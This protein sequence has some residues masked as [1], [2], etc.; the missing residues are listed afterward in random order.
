MS[1]LYGRSRQGGA[2]PLP[3]SLGTNLN[4]GVMGCVAGGGKTFG[5]HPCLPKVWPVVRESWG[6]WLGSLEWTWFL[7]I[8]FREPVASYRQETAV[9]AAGELIS[10]SHPIERLFLCAEPHLSRNTHLHGLLRSKILDPRILA[11]ARRDVWGR[12]FD[13]FGRTRVE[14]P[15]GPGAVAKYVSKYCVKAHGYYELWGASEGVGGTRYQ[16]GGYVL[17]EEETAPAGDVL[18][19]SFG[20]ETGVDCAITQV[21]PA[22]ARS[23][24]KVNTQGVLFT[25]ASGLDTH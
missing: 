24:E 20:R 13:Q 16:P 6:A 11:A 12:L 4:A 2:S 18:G 15:R 5:S 17:A 10:R 22:V 3:V 21:L 23:D 1:G 7:T 25:R 8:T 19:E 9:H 14:N